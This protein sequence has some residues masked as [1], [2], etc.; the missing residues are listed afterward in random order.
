MAVKMINAYAATD[1]SLHRTW[2]E[3][4]TRSAEHTLMREFSHQSGH[5]GITE[6][7]GINRFVGWMLRNKGRVMRILLTA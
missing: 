6:W 4:A 5:V 7:E 3:A 1:G 2:E